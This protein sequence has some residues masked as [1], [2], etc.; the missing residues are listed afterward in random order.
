MAHRCNAPPDGIV[1]RDAMLVA[2][3]F[4]GFVENGVAV[5]VVRNHDV[6]IAAAITNWKAPCVVGV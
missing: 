5:A 2:L 6:L 1:C 3:G 4:E